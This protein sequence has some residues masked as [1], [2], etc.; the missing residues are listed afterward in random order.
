MVSHQPH[1]MHVSRGAYINHPLSVVSLGLLSS[2]PL[3]KVLSYVCF[4]LFPGSYIPVISTDQILVA[5]LEY[6]FLGCHVRSSRRAQSLLLL[7]LALPLQI[8]YLP[9]NL[10]H[11]AHS[12]VIVHFS[13]VQYGVVILDLFEF[14]LE[15]FVLLFKVAGAGQHGFLVSRL[16]E[17]LLFELHG[18]R[19]RIF[20]LALQVFHF[21]HQASLSVFQ[22]VDLVP[23]GLGLV[24]QNCYIAV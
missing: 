11:Q 5:N 10:N 21:G 4:E 24:L 3:P 1:V 2:H 14:E 15:L 9:F 22:M 18:Q 13:D 6:V 7:D 16:R 8:G 17:A 12:V 19:G 23:I 20:K